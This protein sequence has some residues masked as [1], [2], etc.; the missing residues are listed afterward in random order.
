MTHLAKSPETSAVPVNPPAAQ[1]P[2]VPVA[3]RD[4]LMRWLPFLSTPVLLILLIGAWQF[5]VS[6]IGVSEFILPAPADV[7]QALRDLLTGGTIWR[8]LW[9]T[10]YEVLVG[11]LLALIVGTAVGAVLGRV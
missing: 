1:D 10:L 4:N 8:D 3:D 2:D 6:V 5:A 7:A 9:I 11:F